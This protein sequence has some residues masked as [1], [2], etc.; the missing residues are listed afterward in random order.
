MI[1]YLSRHEY[2]NNRTQTTLRVTPDG[3]HRRYSR[4]ASSIATELE[5]DEIISNLRRQF[6]TYFFGSTLTYVTL[7]SGE[8]AIAVGVP[9]AL[10]NNKIRTGSVE[11]FTRQTSW[12]RYF[13]RIQT[14]YGGRVQEGFGSAVISLDMN[15]DGKADLVIGAPYWSS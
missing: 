5:K 10:N 9:G 15:S 13:D 6:G 4:S 12:S 7:Q 8:R 14:I 1:S 3:H 11:L 2:N